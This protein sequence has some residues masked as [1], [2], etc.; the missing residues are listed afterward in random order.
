MGPCVQSIALF[1]K[2]S[3]L[4]IAWSGILYTGSQ[5]GTRAPE[6]SLLSSLFHR[7]GEPR[8][9]ARVWDGVGDA[10][11]IVLSGRYSRRRGCAWTGNTPNVAS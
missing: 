5:L 11:N 3:I 6:A 10:I 9:S 2:K 7:H 8:R 1:K 4:G